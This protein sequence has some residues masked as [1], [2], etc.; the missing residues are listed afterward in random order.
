MP[1]F[2][3]GSNLLDNLSAGQTVHVWVCPFDSPAIDPLLARYESVLSTEELARARRY[4]KASDSRCFCVSRVLL[5]TVLSR[6][7]PGAAQDWCFNLN[8]FGKPFLADKHH[9]A[10]DLQFNVSHT[11]SVAVLALTAGAPLGIDVEDNARQTD[12]LSISRSFFNEDEV[13]AINL[14][15]ELANQRFVEYWTLK[16]SYIKAIGKGLSIRLNSFWF[17]R[18]SERRLL[19]KRLDSHED[20]RQ[21][22]FWQYGLGQHTVSICRERKSPSDVNIQWV[23]CVPFAHQVPVLPQLLRWS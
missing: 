4:L 2:V 15:P 8:A 21:W 1:V 16:E 22:A 12:H 11:K 19:L 9:H 5:R 3:D 6:Y 13:A 17:L 10:V 20:Q 23:E 7:L 14:A 18:P